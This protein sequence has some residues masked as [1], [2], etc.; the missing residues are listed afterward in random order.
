MADRDEAHWDKVHHTMTQRRLADSP[1]MRQMIDVTNRYEGATVI[2]LGDVEGEPEMQAPIPN[3]VADVIETTAM[4]SA[5]TTPTIFVP[6]LDPLSP[7]ANERAANRRGMLYAAW[8]HSS[9]IETILPRSYRHL[10]GYGTHCMIGV[11]DFE[12]GRSRIEVADPLTCYPEHRSPEDTREP[13]NMG[14]IFGRST[15]WLLA[16][17]PECAELFEDASKA[18]GRRSHNAHKAVYDTL[19]DVVEWVDEDFITIGLLGPRELNTSVFTNDLF[20]AGALGKHLRTWENRAGRPPIAAGRRITL[21]AIEGQV[22]KL[23]GLVDM[24]G[25]LMALDVL[26]A[27]KAVFADMVVLD[28]NGTPQLLNASGKWNDG[29]TGEANLVKGSSVQLLQ[30]SPG[31]LTH[32]VADRLEGYFRQS[33]GLSQMSVGQNTNGLR[34]GNALEQM[35]AISLDPRMIEGQRLMSRSLKVMNEGVAAIEKGYFTN[36]KQVFFSGWPGEFGHAKYTPGKDIDSLENAVTYAYPGAD[37]NQLTVAIG[38]AVGAD[39]LSKKTGRSKHPMVGNPE[40]EEREIT[41]QKII[42]AGLGGLLTQANGGEIPL[43][44]VMAIAKGYQK[45][46]DLAKA[47]EDA[48]EAARARQATPAPAE[49]PLSQ[50]GLAS[51]GMGAES[52]VEPGASIPGP[53]SASQDFQALMNAMSAPASA[54]VPA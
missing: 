3:L 53:A 14:R 28:S 35:G 49:D 2:P 18:I 47:V 13:A 50:P 9:M 10:Y 20:P 36:K 37:V 15:D 42:D 27:E 4:R 11:P 33:G 46:G 43:I 22:T 8:D 45:H 26:A 44:D 52:M 12:A 38:Q 25:K 29:R 39:L 7:R 17:Y 23:T 5:S 54:A 16:R 24:M 21:R 34:T 51:P 41:A 32:P 48:D 31:P 30:G 40:A 6:S 19:W 1:L